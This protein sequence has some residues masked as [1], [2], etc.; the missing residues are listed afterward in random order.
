[1]GDGC[2][3]WM[4]QPTQ[5]RSALQEA[6]LPRVFKL[7]RAL[8]LRHLVVV[9]NRNEVSPCSLRVGSLG[10]LGWWWDNM[11]PL[12]SGS[13]SVGLYPVPFLAGGGHGHPQGPRQVPAGEGRPGGALASPDVMRGSSA[14]QRQALAPQSRGPPF[15]GGRERTGPACAGITVP[16]TLAWPCCP[17]SPAH[18]CLPTSTLSS[19]HPFLCF[20]EGS[21]HTLGSVSSWHRLSL[22]IG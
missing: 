17:G 3:L 16:G 5:P 8:G 21:K 13:A 1:M 11:L 12:P 6:S 4:L 15:A 18:H 2:W 10:S 20:T 7:F 14:Q 22:R 9:D 19:S